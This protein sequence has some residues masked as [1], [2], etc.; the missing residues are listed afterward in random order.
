MRFCNGCI[1]IYTYMYMC[2]C[3]ERESERA[4]ERDRVCR[5][6]SERE[7]EL[8][9]KVLQCTEMSKGFVREV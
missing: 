5:R 1:Y 8:V 9:D 2:V 6:E 4:S 3:R 7:N